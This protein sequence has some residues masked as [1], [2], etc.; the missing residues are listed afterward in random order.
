[1]TKK[2]RSLIRDWIAKY[3]NWAKEEYS[4][5]SSSGDFDDFLQFRLNQCAADVLRLLLS[6]F[7]GGV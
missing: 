1:M 3:D 2:E 4:T 6:E 5:Y 7:D